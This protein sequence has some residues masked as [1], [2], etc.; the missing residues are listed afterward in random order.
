MGNIG[1]GTIN[2]EN[3]KLNVNGNSYFKD[4]STFAN[5]IKQDNVSTPN[6][7][8]ANIGIGIQLQMF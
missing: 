4:I 1:I 3:Y 8:L 7:L 5:S 2:S 6:Y